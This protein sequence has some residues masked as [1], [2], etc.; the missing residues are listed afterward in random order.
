LLLPNPS[1]RVENFFTYLA[2]CIFTASDLTLNDVLYNKI[3]ALWFL[4]TCKSMSA[5]SEEFPVKEEIVRP[6]LALAV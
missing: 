2:R 3:K 4:L 5:F 6:L 1:L